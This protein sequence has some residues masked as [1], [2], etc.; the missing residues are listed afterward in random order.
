MHYY[1]ISVKVANKTIRYSA[2]TK[3]E[4][5]ELLGALKRLKMTNYKTYEVKR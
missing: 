2:R 1:F 5:K 3:R 4:F